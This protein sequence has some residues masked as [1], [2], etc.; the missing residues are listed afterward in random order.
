M[1][2]TKKQR[3]EK[4]EEVF[5]EGLKIVEELKEERK[6]TKKTR[7]PSKDN[8]CRKYF[9]HEQPVR[10]TINGKNT[11]VGLFDRQKNV[12]SFDGVIYKTM[13]SFASAHYIRDRPDRC[14]NVNGWKE[15]ECYVNGKW[16]STLDLP[17]L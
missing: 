7:L 5:V 10:H 13:T 2:T 12:I 3:F 15:C 6:Q 1:E 17:Q 14:K 4:L 16:I 11:W 9:T 8:D